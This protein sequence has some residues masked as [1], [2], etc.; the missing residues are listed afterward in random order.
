MTRDM[1]AMSTE[2]GCVSTSAPEELR[3]VV[4]ETLKDEKLAT[5]Q[6]QAHTLCLQRLSAV[7]TEAFHASLQ[8][9]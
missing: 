4:D 3:K 7:S 2:I 5:Q 1:T 9:S 8:V 6:A